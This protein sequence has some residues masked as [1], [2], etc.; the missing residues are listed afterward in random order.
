[1]KSYVLGFV[2]SRNHDKVVLIE[3]ARPEWQAGRLNGVGGHIETDESPEQAMA[4]EFR[5]ETLCEDTLDWEPF[6]RLRGDG[7]TVWLFHA[8]YQTVPIYN[9]HEEGK[10][11]VHHLS[12]VLGRETSKG[13]RPLPNLRYLI[14]M[15]LNHISREDKAEFFEIQETVPCCARC[16]RDC[17]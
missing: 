7:W 8:H 13:C 4:R 1:M 14:P 12:I 5:E 16:S 6:G 11:S 2:F 3:K 17:P 15:A 10:V 9:E